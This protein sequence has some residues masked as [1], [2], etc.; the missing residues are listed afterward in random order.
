MPRAKPCSLA[1]TPAPPEPA[2]RVLQAWEGTCAVHSRG[3]MVS[4]LVTRQCEGDH[5]DDGGH[6]PRGRS[7]RRRRGAR[8]P[9]LLSWKRIDVA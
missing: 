4:G 8:K 7:R 3:L 6:E 2:I 5:E 1:A 9:K